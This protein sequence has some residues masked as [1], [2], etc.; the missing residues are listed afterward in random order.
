MMFLW[1]INAIIDAINE[2]AKKYIAEGKSVGIMATEETKDNTKRV[3]ISV[4]SRNN[5]ETIAHNLFS[6]IIFDEKM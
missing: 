4:G 1:R 5:K 3:N 2:Y 6:T